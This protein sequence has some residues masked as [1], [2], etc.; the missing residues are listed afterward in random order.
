MTAWFLSGNSSFKPQHCST[1]K[2]Q[3]PKSAGSGGY[4][5]PENPGKGSPEALARRDKGVF[6]KL[7]KLPDCTLAFF[8]DMVYYSSAYEDQT[9]HTQVAQE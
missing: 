8:P 9:Y 5:P 1:A 3:H 4:S 7:G 2:R 6:L